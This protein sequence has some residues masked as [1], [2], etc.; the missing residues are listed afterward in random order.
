MLIL[1]A[2]FIII[3]IF[4]CAIFLKGNQKNSVPMDEIERSDI[5]TDN[6]KDFELAF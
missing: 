4:I 3:A 1:V 2:I 6:T 5:E